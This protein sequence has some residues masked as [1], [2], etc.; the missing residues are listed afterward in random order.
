MSMSIFSFLFP[1][2]IH[3]IFR[4]LKRYVYLSI[5]F[6]RFP[7]SIIKIILLVFFQSVYCLL[8]Q[9]TYSMTMSLVL[10]L[11][12]L[13]FHFEVFLFEIE[14]MKVLIKRIFRFLFNKSIK[15][16]LGNYYLVKCVS[17]L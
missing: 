7:S 17:I 14:S 9:I 1:V 6:P 10:L 3:I 5:C 16:Y 4:Y 12:Q 11:W 13:H 8:Y 2:K 15:V